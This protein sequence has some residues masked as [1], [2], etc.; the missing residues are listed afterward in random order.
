MAQVLHSDPHDQR[1][2]IRGDS[3]RQKV[4]DLNDDFRKSLGC[5]RDAANHLLLTRGV[6]AKF[7]G[8][9]GAVLALLMAFN[10]FTKENDPWNEHDFGAFE[11]RGERI[12]WKI[13]TYDREGKGASPNPADPSVTSRVLTVMLASE[14]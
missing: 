2:D 3:Y 13:D 1:T 10:D 6:L 4:R 9:M 12:F 8:D 11:F 7:K 14:Y 5:G